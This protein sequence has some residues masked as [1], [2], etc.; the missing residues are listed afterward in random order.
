[1]RYNS[2][3]KLTDNISAIRIALE[4]QR[5]DQISAEETAMLQ[6]YA[7]FGGLKA[8]LFPNG[9]IEEWNKL[10]ASKEDLKLYPQ[11]MELHKFLNDTLGAGE[12]K[13][14][15][16]S[17]KNSVLSAFY[18]PSFIPETL[19][20]V[21]S[22][23]GIEIKNLYEPSAGA[24]VFIS[25]AAKAFPDLQEINAVEKDVLTANILSSF[26]ST[27]EVPAEVQIK[28]LEQ[29]A[30]AENGK[31]DLI[32]SNIPFGNFKIFDQS[33]SFQQAT[34]KIHNYFF[35]KGLDKIREGGLLAF[36]TTDSFL[37]SPSNEAAR[38]YVFNNADFISVSV[39]P[40]NLMTD[41]GNT[42]APSHLLILQKNTS[43]EKLSF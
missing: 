41:T 25:E 32:A 17:V 43:K 6:R 13:Q 11:M 20:K 30:S 21:L 7:G 36:V 19:F 26:T 10:N 16:D 29:T 31:Y 33:L 12:Y 38:R 8:V 3:Q 22:E 5:R 23:Q 1:M 15:M 35:A 9:P 14:V 28:G 39:L 18:T 34:E 2:Q 42:E 40:D 27:L 24:G 4:W 37:N